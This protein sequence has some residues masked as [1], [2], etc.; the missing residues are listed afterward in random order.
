MPKYERETLSLHGTYY[1]WLWQG[2]EVVWELAFSYSH[3]GEAWTRSNGM[4]TVFVTGKESVQRKV[5]TKNMALKWARKYA[6]ENVWPEFTAKYGSW[7][8]LPKRPEL[9]IGG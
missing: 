6:K 3:N 9:V 4:M 5:S 1:Y 7:R 2:K 8:K